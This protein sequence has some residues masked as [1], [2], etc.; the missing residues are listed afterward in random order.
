MVHHLLVDYL[1]RIW[2]PIFIHHSYACRRGKGVHRGVSRLPT[3]I[4]QV[5]ANGSRPAWT[6]QL[7]IRNYFMSIDKDI[8]F[9]LLSAKLQVGMALWL[10]RILVYHDCTENYLFRG[11]DDLI[12]QIPAHKTLFGTPDNQGLPI[13][14]L[15]NHFFVNV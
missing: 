14:N 4:R 12:N 1:E 13:G 6:L 7:D 9:H 2:E 11:R 5:T 10:T 15:N 3:F 8:L